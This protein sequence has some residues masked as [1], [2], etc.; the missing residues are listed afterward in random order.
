SLYNGIALNL[1]TNAL[2]AVTAKAG[3][4]RKEIAFRSW[5]ERSSHFLEVSDTGIGIPTAL[6]SRIFDPLFTTTASN[7]DPLGSGMGL[8]LSLVKRG[9]AAFGG[10]V[11]VVKPPP[12]F[13]TCFRLKLPFSQ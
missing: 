9:T 3:P 13:S 2:K 8:G 4:G 10:R 11:D 5:N 6:K 1:Y 12:G 7:R